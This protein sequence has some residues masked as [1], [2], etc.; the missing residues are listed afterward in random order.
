M[1]DHSAHLARARAHLPAVVA[2]RRAIHRRPELGNDLPETRDRVLEALAPLGLEIERSEATTG[3]VATLR[4]GRTGPCILLRADMDALP[5]PEDTG[6]EF[7]SE[8]EGRMHACGHDAHTAMLVGAAILLAEQQGHA[9][10]RHPVL[11]RDRRGGPLRRAPRP[12]GEG[13]LERGRAARR[14]LRPAHGLAHAGG[15][16][17]IQ[18]RRVLSL[19]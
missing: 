8:I 14:G 19:R 16:G 6:L 13:L 4:G 2:L 11:L 5:M 18:A 3:F 1:T 12:R 15:P 10:R 7:A 9:R 17:R